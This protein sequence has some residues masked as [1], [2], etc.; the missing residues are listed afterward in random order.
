MGHT[1]RVGDVF[2]GG[3]S[4]P[5]EAARIGCDVYASDLNPVAALL[6]WGALNIVGGGKEATDRVAAAQRRVFDKV[7]AQVN[8]WGIERDSETGWM[9]DA[10]LYCTETV[11]PATGW[12]VPLAPSWTIAK[13]AKQVIARLIPDQATCSFD[14]EIIEGVTPAELEQAAAEGTAKDGVRCPVT[15]EGVWLTPAQRLTTATA[16][17]R[18]SGGLRRWEN[19]DLVPRIG[20]VFGERL[21]CVR[22]VDPATG[23][24]HYRA[25]T[26]ADLGREARVLIHLRERFA[27]WQA[28]G[29]VP[30]RAIEPGQDINRPTNARGWTYWH[31]MFN[32]RNLLVNGLFAEM[33]QQEC[34]ND[35]KAMLLMIGRLANYNSRLCLWNPVRDSVQD[36]YSQ[37]SLKTPLVNYGTRTV[38]SLASVF[39]APLDS[40]SLNGSYRLELVDAKAVKWDADLWLTDPG[41]GDMFS[42]DELSEFFLA[43]YDRRLPELFP[44]W[45]SDSKRALAVK[46]EGATFR[47]TLAACYKRLAAQMPD[48]A[49]QVVMFTHQDPEV[50]ADL[51]LVL[52]SAG[53]QVSA[54]WTVAT[55]TGSLGIRQGNLVQGTVLLVL[56]KRV[57]DRHGSMGDLF[58]DIRVEVEMQIAQM[59]EIDAGDD[60]N[61]G[62]ADYQ[63]AAYAA[64]LRVL[65]GYASVDGIDVERELRAPRSR[66]RSAI[67]RLIDQAVKIASDSL[68]PRGMDRSVWRSLTPEERFYLKGIEVEARGEARQGVYQE[69]ARG[70]GADAYRPLLAS[71]RANESRLQSPSEFAGRDLRR[72]GDAGFGGTMLR[73]LLYAVYQTASHPERDPRLARE[74]LRQT[75]PDYWSRKAAAMALVKYLAD[76]AAPLTTGNW[77]VDIHAA[78]LLRDSLANH[79][80]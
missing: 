58:P 4:I 9:A 35:A 43:W 25:P 21:Y 7:Q 52:W 49:F 22:W 23:T 13:R 15:R 67:A 38:N 17:L 75:L 8:A 2:S 36:V 69:L 70:Y 61:F 12:R 44:G 46:G 78:R 31:H 27:D 34:E 48:D 64:A 50:W 63:L 59:T 80:M 42:Y 5:F 77:A 19:N 18:G 76:T 66:E 72:L 1:P 45:Y 55:E 10:Y 11:D 74:H 62:D 20:D 24:R 14:F 37:P 33:S 54:A 29:Y 65:T 30:S 39:C 60:P 28:K 47:T 73:H 68:M 26:A 32:P 79:A 16:Q 3:G 57:T 6:T 53:L 56:R 71:G 40:A 51:T 41:Y